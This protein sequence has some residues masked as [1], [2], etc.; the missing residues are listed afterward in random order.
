MRRKGFYLLLIPLLFSCGFSH[1][2]FSI[3]HN[4]ESLPYFHRNGDSLFL[5]YGDGSYQDATILTTGNELVSRVNRHLPTLLL[6]YQSSC[7]W[8]ERFE[9]TFLEVMKESDIEFLSLAN[10]SSI[11]GGIG[12]LKEAFPAYSSIEPATPQIYM[13]IDEENYSLLDFSPYIDSS[14]RFSSFIGE[15]GNWTFVYHFS[16]YSAYS[17]FLKNKEALCFYDDGSQSSYSFFDSSLKEKAEKSLDKPLAIFDAKRASNEEKEAVL[18]DYFHNMTSSSLS[19]HLPKEE[20][21]QSYAI[22]DE[23]AMSLISSYY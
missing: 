1:Y 10:S 20:S 2:D 7:S 8:C 22:E 9:P 17:S 11:L 4:D 5:D 16:S 3:N 18:Q 6:L 13:L 19:I 23:M 14:S 12:A 15:K 21:Y